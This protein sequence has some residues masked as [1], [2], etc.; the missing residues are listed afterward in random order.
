M[1]RA[2]FTASTH[3]GSVEASGHS[4]YALF[5]T[6]LHDMTSQYIIFILHYLQ[7]IDN[8]GRGPNLTVVYRDGL[9][10]GLFNVEMGFNV[11]I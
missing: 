3:R 4:S 7:Y 10:S 5:Q 2:Y 9:L 11:E 1:W 8:S 6:Y